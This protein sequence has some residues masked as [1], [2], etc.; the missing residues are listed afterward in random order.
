MKRRGFLKQSAF[1]TAGTMLIPHFLKAYEAQATGQ[2]MAPTG[3]ILV[4][5][6]LSGG[7]DGLN[8]VIP[9]RNDIYYRER[10]TIA[11]RPE[12]VLP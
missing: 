10:P 11:I 6:Q 2:T 8:T 5:V 4:V 7:N 12:K 9:F 1:T 3:K